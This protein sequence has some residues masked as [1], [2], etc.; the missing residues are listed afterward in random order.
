MLRV[1]VNIRL[2]SVVPFVSCRIRRATGVIIRLVVDIKK[3]SGPQM[4]EVPAHPSVCLIVG[5]YAYWVD[6]SAV[7]FYY[8][9]YVSTVSVSLGPYWTGSALGPA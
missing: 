1:R 7:V 3:G 5:P 8:I 4:F 2:R 9:C 6:K